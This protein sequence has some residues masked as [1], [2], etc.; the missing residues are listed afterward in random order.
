MFDLSN[1]AESARDSA[2]ALLGAALQ[3]DFAYAT[4]RMTRADAVETRRAN[5]L[6]FGSRR[7]GDKKWEHIECSPTDE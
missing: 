5:G 1:G 6:P 4:L 2:F 7:N 3:F